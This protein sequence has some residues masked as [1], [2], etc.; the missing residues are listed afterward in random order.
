MSKTYKEQEDNAALSKNNGKSIRYRLRKQQE[1]EAQR[2]QKEAL[3]R[4]AEESQETSYY[5]IKAE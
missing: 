1:I 4:L 5:N 2:E 3:K